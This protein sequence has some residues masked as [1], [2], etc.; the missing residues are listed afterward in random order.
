MKFLLLGYYLLFFNFVKSDVCYEG[1][2]CFTTKPPFYDIISRPLTVLPENPKKIATKFTLFNRKA[3]K[4]GV[5]ITWFNE[6]LYYIPLENTRFIIHGFL[7]NGNKVWISTMK[8]NLLKYENSNVIV[9]DWSKGNRLPYTQAT[10]NAQIVGI[11]IAILVNS[12]IR[13]GVLIADNVHIIGHSLGAHV[14]GYAGERIT[15]KVGRISGLDPAGLYFENT[16]P[17]VRIDSTDAKFVDIIHTDTNPLGVGLLQ[18]VGH[19]DF[20]PNGGEN[21]PNCPITP[22]KVFSTLTNFLSFQLEEVEAFFTCGH[23]AAIHFFT[24]SILNTECKFTAFRCNDINNFKKGNCMSCPSN[25]CNNMGFHASPLNDLGE[26]YLTTTQSPD[27]PFCYYHYQL[28]LVSADLKKKQTSGKFSIVLKGSLNKSKSFV[29]D[30]HKIKFKENLTVKNLIEVSKNL[31]TIKSL[32]L[33]FT[34]NFCFSMSC[35]YD[36][37]SWSFKAVKLYDGNLQ[38]TIDLCSKSENI[39]SGSFLEYFPCNEKFE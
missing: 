20:Y 32:L 39:V 33:S 23:M 9:V 22:N 13:K 35:W 16:D 12:F 1:Y 5:E 28:T 37:D 18:K 3:P 36:I 17:R 34:Q 19:V 21:Q 14:A 11:D 29:I 31:G 25:G 15:P 10:A 30:D 26:L 7:Q 8:E 2:G 24:D 4:N 38:K 6:S 27:A